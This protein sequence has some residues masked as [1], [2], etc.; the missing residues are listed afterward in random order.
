MD[1]DPSPIKY[2]A[3]VDLSNRNN[4]H[5]AVIELVGGLGRS[6]LKILE[7]GCSSGYMGAVLRSRGHHVVGVEPSPAA[8]Q[9][10]RSVLDDAFCGTLDEFAPTAARGHYDVIT[11]ADV[12]EHIADPVA[13]LRL[14]GELLAPGGHIVISVPNVTHGSIRAMLLDGRWDY[15]GLGI[16]DRTHLRF[17][18]RRALLDC[19]GRAGFAVQELR[20]TLA[21]VLHGLEGVEP[22]IDPRVID[23]VSACSTDDDVDTYQFV[24]MLAQ[25]DASEVAAV[26]AQWVDK[27]LPRY[28]VPKW[29]DNVLPVRWRA[30][31][32]LSL[33]R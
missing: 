25:R 7:V 23:V 15:Q 27:K 32:R 18:S 26:N 11:L 24:A 4:S 30:I 28:D 16:L 5:T 1:H 20:R 22:P 13:A 31:A 19:I 17:F 33:Q 3:H 12:L 9:A 8:A 6:A 10:A 29:I 14:C 2:E 21:P